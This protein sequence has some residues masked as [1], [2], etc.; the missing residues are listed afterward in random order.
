[1]ISITISEKNLKNKS[2]IK[3]SKKNIVI[4]GA[5][6]GVGSLTAKGLAELG[7]HII[8][9]GRNEK[10]LIELEDEI[11]KGGIGRASSYVLADMSE[12]EEVLKVG[13]KIV[14]D[15]DK[16]DVWINNVGVNNHNAIGPTW[17][18]KAKNWWTEVTLNL[19]TAFLGTQVAINLMKEQNTGYVLNLGGGGVADPK[20]FGS[21][22]GASKSAVVKFSETVNIELEKEGLGIKVFAFNPGFIKNERTEILVKSDVGRKYMPNLEEVMN[23]GAMSKIEDTVT[24]IDTMISGRADELAGKYFQADDK[25]IE[26]A[27]EHTETFIAERKNVLR[28][29]NIETRKRL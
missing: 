19:Y 24:L 14:E 9:L 23:H 27:I 28:V 29:R 2:N 18:L 25:N 4:T 1:M 16:I 6:G 13:Q 15:H 21:A 17:E 26:E 11:N 7:H 12:E 5:T 22:Y 3:M 8:C 20:P 10:R